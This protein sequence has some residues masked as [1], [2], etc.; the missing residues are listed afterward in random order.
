MDRWR[1]TECERTTDRR[2]LAPRVVT[3]RAR[4]VPKRGS[5][6]PTLERQCAES[7]TRPTDDRRP[8]QTNQPTPALRT[9]TP[10][11]DLYVSD[12]G[13]VTPFT[14]GVIFV[15]FT[16]TESSQHYYAPFAWIFEVR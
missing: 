16:V 15:A 11:Q 13:S 7:P 1:Q 12:G 4:S 3:E 8:R 2:T 14:G 10:K 6:R 5:D 9:P